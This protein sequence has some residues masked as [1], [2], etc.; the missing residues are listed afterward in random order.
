MEKSQIQQEREVAQAK[1]AKS[2]STEK[3]LKGVAL[4]GVDDSKLLSEIAKMSAVTPYGVSS[5]FNIRIG[6]AKDIL[7]ELERRRVLM[8]VGGNAR[9][10]IYRAV[11]A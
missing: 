10:R 2:G 11:A 8:S 4:Q 1:K 6:A 9:V 5:Q 3:K 7:E